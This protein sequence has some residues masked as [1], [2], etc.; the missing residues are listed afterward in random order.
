MDSHI[1]MRA[2]KFVPL[3]PQI[4]HRYLWLTPEIALTPLKRTFNLAPVDG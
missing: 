3:F 2:D 1:E 4:T